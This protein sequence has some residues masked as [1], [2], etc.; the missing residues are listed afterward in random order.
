MVR[1]FPFKC[2]GC[3]AGYVVV[4]AD[5]GPDMLDTIEGQVDCRVC[6]APFVGREGDFVVKY[7]RSGG[8]PTAQRVIVSSGCR[9]PAQLIWHVSRA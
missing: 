9:Q 1:T 7:F 2:P 3:G 8:G 4:K 5:A 6:G